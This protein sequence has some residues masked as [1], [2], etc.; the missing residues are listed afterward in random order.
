MNTEA[1]FEVLLPPLRHLRQVVKLQ[2]K[3][4]QSKLPGQMQ[5]SFQKD[6][7]LYAVAENL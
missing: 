3:K 2:G 7:H 5:L 1:Q 4:G 6:L